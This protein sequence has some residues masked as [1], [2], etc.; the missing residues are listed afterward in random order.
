M[1]YRIRS[2]TV[3]HPQQAVQRS[4]MLFQAAH[5]RVIETKQ[6]CQ[7]VKQTSVTPRNE[8]ATAKFEN[9]TSRGPGY[10]C[11]AR[12]LM[13]VPAHQCYALLGDA[14]KLRTRDVAH[15]RQHQMVYSASAISVPYTR[16]FTM[17]SDLCRN[18]SSGSARYRD[19][20]TCQTEWQCHQQ[21]RRIRRIAFA[22]LNNVAGCTCPS[23]LPKV[24]K[25]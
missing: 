14:D 17:F 8:L 19:N 10:G 15:R 18:T 11:S 24:R 25:K 21:I 6:I 1:A 22:T 20:Q 13:P 4:T 12:R 5:S 23:R 7:I 3:N 9:T 2:G 16:H